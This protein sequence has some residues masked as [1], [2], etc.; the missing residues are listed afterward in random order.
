VGRFYQQTFVDTCSKVSFAK[1]Y[2]GEA[3]PPVADLLNDRVVPFFDSHGI[4]LSRVLTDRD[5]EYCGNP[6]YRECQL[7]LAVEN[8]DHTRTKKESPQANGIVERPHKTMPGRVRVRAGH[9]N[10]R[11]IASSDSARKVFDWCFNRVRCVW[12]AC[13]DLAGKIFECGPRVRPRCPAK[14]KVAPSLSLRVV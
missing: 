10:G 9:I 13:D 1:F 12:A 14:E 11:R 6:E 4:T 5:T 2:G 3:P 7:Y 8:I